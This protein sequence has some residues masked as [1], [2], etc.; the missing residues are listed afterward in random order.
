MPGSLIK[1]TIYDIPLIFQDKIY[2][3]YPTLP[4]DRKPSG[5]KEFNA[6]AQKYNISLKFPIA[7]IHAF[8]SA[9]VLVEG[10]KRSG[11]QL[12]RARLV[13]ELEGLLQFETGLSQPITFHAN[14]RVG[15]LGAYVVAV[16]LEEKTFRPAGDWIKLE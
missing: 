13:T 7:Q 8:L 9:K 12:S 16:D 1:K 10:I 2:L 11:R 3:S 14:R 15:A 4:S 6:L 5:I